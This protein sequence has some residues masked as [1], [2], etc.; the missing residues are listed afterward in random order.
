MHCSSSSD[1]TTL[2]GRHGLLQDG[3]FLLSITHAKFTSQFPPGRSGERYNATGSLTG[4]A[5]GA[6]RA[7]EQCYL[8]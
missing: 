5:C 3:Q 1:A 2:A 8:R 6:V 7:V 4:L